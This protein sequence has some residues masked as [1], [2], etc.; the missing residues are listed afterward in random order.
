MN[1]RSLVA[2]LAGALVASGLALFGLSERRVAARGNPLPL[3]IATSATPVKTPLFSVRRIPGTVAEPLMSKP[4][5]DRLAALNTELPRSSCVVVEADGVAVLERD[6]DTALIPASNMKL[7]TAAVAL[8]AMGPDFRFVT[9][10]FGELDPNTNR[11]A[12]LYVVGA[13]DPLL[14][15]PKYRE[16]STTYDFYADTPWTPLDSL[17][18]Q[19]KATG[20]ASVGSLIGDGSRYDLSDRGPGANV[21]RTNYGRGSDAR[22]ADPTVHALD[23]LRAMLTN[24]SI[25]TNGPLRAGAMDRELPV[26]AQVESAPLRDIVAN[27]LT[28]SDN[29]TAEMLWREIAVARGKPGTRAG[30]AEAVRETLTSWGIALD[31]VNLADGSGLDRTNAVT[32]RALVGVLRHVG[33]RGD[34]AQGLAVPGRPGTLQ[35]ELA[36][37]PVRD[38][39]AAKT[40]TLIDGTVKALSG[41][42]TSSPD[43]VITFAAIVN[44]APNITAAKQTLSAVCEAFATFPGRIDLVA[45]GP[46]T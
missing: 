45:F 15:T 26:L 18:E 5:R 12:E 32:C 9:K 3:Q 27:M 7:L 14:A 33:P 1:I 16:A 23:Q 19:L 36:G 28:T 44:N 2:V 25:A 46:L 38:V 11:V 24:Q 30:G 20:V 41:F 35:N 21:S 4:L 29:D 37:C 10:V 22:N 34:V 13:G 31:G 39:V 6:A 40:G 42:V 43:H 17:A 8:D